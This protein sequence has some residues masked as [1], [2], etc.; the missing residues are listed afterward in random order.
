M[1]IQANDDGYDIQGGA[2][3]D[4]SSDS[5]KILRMIKIPKSLEVEIISSDEAKEDENEKKAES[6]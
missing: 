4:N 3:A 5:S 2:K 6:M 1:D